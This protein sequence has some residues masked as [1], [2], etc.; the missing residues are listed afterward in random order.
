MAQQK[1]GNYHILGKIASGGQGKVHRA[2]D[3]AI[4]RM[5]ALKELRSEGE[6][7]FEGETAIE[8]FRREALLVSRIHHPNVVRMFNVF[9]YDDRRFIAMELLST[10][11]GDLLE[12]VGRLPMARSVDI[13]RQAALG[14]EAALQQN[15]IHRD[16]KPRNLLVAADGA[17]KVSDFGLARA[18][19]L[20]TITHTGAALGTLSYTSP[21]EWNGIRADTRSDIYSLG[22]TL[23]EMLTGSVPFRGDTLPEIMGQHIN[24]PH[25]PVRNKRPEISSELAAVVDR[26]LQKDPIQRYQTPGELADALADPSITDWA[27][28]VALYDATDGDNWSDNDN[29]LTNAP[30][31]DWFGIET[32][33]NGR[34]TKIELGSN[35][36]DGC[37]PPELGNLAALQVLSMGYDNYLS[38]Q[39]PSEL[40]NLTNLKVLWF[41]C[42]GNLNGK[43]PP[44]L[45]NLS[46]LEELGLDNNS[47]D[48]EIPPELGN[49]INLR[50][51]TL[52]WN[53]LSGEI[54]VELG[55]L[56]NL[57]CLNL[58][59][60]DN[61]LSGE[62]PP[63]LRGL[64]TYEEYMG[65]EYGV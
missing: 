55:N 41:S 14:L 1:I 58:I 11:V 36:L 27:A 12:T 15:V 57:V 3:S 46:K 39:I 6:G 23:Y 32:D 13:C 35:D 63:A 5:V 60:G 49:L 54:P 64:P 45:G 7:L 51:L 47:L 59:G 37:I 40:G 24:T 31:G 34:V 50:Q 43:I 38:G 16:I 52:S 20:T 2:W 18:S 8:R 61:N 22:I 56:I 25:D 17:I 10:S 33:A 28:L 30:I 4:G 53:Q 9:E 21:E 44:E 29:W 62:I 65:Y 19:D 42:L 26:C 48:G